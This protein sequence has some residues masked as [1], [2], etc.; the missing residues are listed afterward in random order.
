MMALV[1]GV[2]STH[3][4]G[5]APRLAA[6]S[7]IAPEPAKR[8]A[9]AIPAR[10]S[11]TGSSAVPFHEAMAENTASRTRSVVGRVSWVGGV[12]MRRPP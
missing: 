2:F 7:P 10:A 8:S 5:P 11:L 4:T 3:T 6:S 9:K 12:L 1:A